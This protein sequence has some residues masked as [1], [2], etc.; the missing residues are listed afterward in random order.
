M[1]MPKSHHAQAGTPQRKPS[2]CR[3]DNRLLR[4]LGS[5]D[6][7]KRASTCSHKDCLLEAD[8]SIP[9][10]KYDGVT[11]YKPVCRKHRDC[12]TEK[13]VKG[14]AGFM[15]VDEVEVTTGN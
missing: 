14:F 12:V 7:I 10:G 8:C 6:Q 3:V 9:M 2:L 13:V 1:S 4:K 11:V 15:M 5:V